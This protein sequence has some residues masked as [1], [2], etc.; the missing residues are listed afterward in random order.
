LRPFY[1]LEVRGAWT[2]SLE[3]DKIAGS[4]FGRRAARPKGEGQDGPSLKIA[5]SDFGRRERVGPKGYGQE[6]HSNLT[7]S[8]SCLLPIAFKSKP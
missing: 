5:G 6:G 3:F 1:I 7:L 8:A 2:N 4:D